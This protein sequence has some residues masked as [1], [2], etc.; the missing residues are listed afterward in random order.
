[1]VFSDC[2]FWQVAKNTINFH[3]LIASPTSAVWPWKLFLSNFLSFGRAERWPCCEAEQPG[4]PDVVSTFGISEV[5]IICSYICG[6]AAGTGKRRSTSIGSR[7]KFK[8][9]VS[10]LRLREPPARFETAEVG[11]VEYKISLEARFC[12]GSSNKDRVIKE[13]YE[14]RFL[15]RILND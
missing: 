15:I 7:W 6:N 2:L 3:H 8:N 4:K 9:V 12:C 1:M 14:I 13:S 5:A 11:L 10:T